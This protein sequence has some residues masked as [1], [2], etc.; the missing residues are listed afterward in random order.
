[1]HRIRSFGLDGKSELC[2]KAQATHDAQGV[3]GEALAR[4]TDGT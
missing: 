1:M 2:G 4:I 3:F